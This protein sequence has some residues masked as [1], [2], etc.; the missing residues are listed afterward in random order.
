MR[1]S[2]WVENQIRKTSDATALQY[3][4][5]RV[6]YEKNT[7]RSPRYQ[8]GGNAQGIVHVDPV[9]QYYEIGRESNGKERPYIRQQ[10]CIT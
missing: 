1:R 7:G 4:G 9:K 5:V 8:P 2:N 6:V 10:V 3:I